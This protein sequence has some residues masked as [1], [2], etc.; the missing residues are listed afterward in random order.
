MENEVPEN[1]L[2]SQSYD[3]KSNPDVTS[4]FH[5]ASRTPST[6]HWRK[7]PHLRVP[8]K[9]AGPKFY[10]PRRTVGSNTDRKKEVEI[11]EDQLRKLTNSTDEN[12]PVQSPVSAR[13]NSKANKQVICSSKLV[14]LKK[15]SQFYQSFDP[16]LSNFH[17]K[18][19]NFLRKS[20]KALS[21]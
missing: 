12:K 8:E 6:S 10:V 21:M 7:L 11:N 16:T 13:H 19:L 3:S 18:F 20:E 15:K 2:M 5:Q 4:Q 17:T 9:T 14:K 1:E